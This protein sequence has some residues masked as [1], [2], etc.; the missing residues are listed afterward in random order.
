MPIQTIFFAMHNYDQLTSSIKNPDLVHIHTVK[1]SFLLHKHDQ[2]EFLAKC[3]AHLNH[4]VKYQ[5]KTP[6]STIGST[7]AIIMEQQEKQQ[8]AKPKE[9]AL[10]SFPF[11]KS[12]SAC[13]VDISIIIYHKSHCKTVLTKHARIIAG[14][15][16]SRAAKQPQV[17]KMR[18]R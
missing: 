5:I 16:Q 8:D 7:I 3:L 15:R 13:R 12:C 17:V 10:S 4:W 9:S 1:K 6:K 11:F 2:S 18:V 14:I